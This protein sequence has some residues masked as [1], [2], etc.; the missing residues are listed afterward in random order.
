MKIVKMTVHMPFNYGEDTKEKDAAEKAQLADFLSA[1]GLTANND[2]D[3]GV[4]ICTPDHVI[5]AMQ[6]FGVSSYNKIGVKKV[7][8]LFDSVDETAERLDTLLTRMQMAATKIESQVQCL[9]ETTADGVPRVD[10]LW[11]N[12]TQ[13]PVVGTLLHQV[14]ELSLCEN[15][16]T[17]ELQGMLNEGWRLIAVCPQESR[18]P[19]Y[20]LGRTMS[21]PKLPNG[22]RRGSS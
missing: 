5:N 6:C 15:F 16:C 19:D 2:T 20:I 1:N 9:Y 22:A 4:V 14:N 7:E 8:V 11:N 10:G 21:E 17:D 3:K 18:R 13:S 12:K